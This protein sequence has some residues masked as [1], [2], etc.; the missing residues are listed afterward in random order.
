MDL[1]KAYERVDREALCNVLKTYGVKRT[2]IKVFYREASACVRVDGV[3]SESFPTGVGVRQGCVTSPWLFNIFMDGC[4]REMKAKVGN[5][6][7]R[8]KM[9]GNGWA[10]VACLFADD[11]VLFAE[12]K[13]KRSSDNGR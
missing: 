11:T 8:L 13:V 10:V 3:L 2:V 1:E 7:A 4:M 5:I 6:G 12:S 9:N